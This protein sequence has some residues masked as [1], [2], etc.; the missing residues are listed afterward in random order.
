MA[1]TSASDDNQ[2]QD[3]DQGLRIVWRVIEEQKTPTHNLKQQL[4]EVAGQL[5]ELLRE[6]V[7]GNMNNLLNQAE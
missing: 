2:S 1:N 7:Q 6:G 3:E 5:H 4:K